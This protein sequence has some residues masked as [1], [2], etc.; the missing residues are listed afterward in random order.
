MI[1][2]RKYIV[3]NA[4]AWL[5]TLVVGLFLLVML[6]EFG[7]RLNARHEARALLAKARTQVRAG[8]TS[9]AQRS[10][11]NALAAAPSIA[12]DIMKLFSGH[13]LGMPVLD[14]RL[15]QVFTTQKTP[16]TVLAQY[17]LLAGRPEQALEPLRRYEKSGGKQP[18]PYLWL[19]RLYADTGDF[20][21]AR[22]AFDTYW[23]LSRSTYRIGPNEWIAKNANSGPPLDRAWKMFRMGLW[24]DVTFVIPSSVTQPERLFYRA[25]SYDLNGDT[26]AAIELYAQLIN[27][28][29][30][31]LPAL[32]RLHFLSAEK[33]K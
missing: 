25:L 11:V 31:H 12:P 20:T 10:A 28:R 30:T 27:E 2:R 32:K 4:G 3:F 23:K 1:E 8:N 33:G 6:R 22:K 9:D 18:G 19:G 29:P 26:A 7:S 21:S 5:A 13:L 24:D 15:R 14:E 17:E 16:D